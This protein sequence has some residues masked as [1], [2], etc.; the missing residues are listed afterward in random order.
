M[1]IAHGAKD[2]ERLSRVFV[3]AVT[4]L[5]FV[6]CLGACFVVVNSDR[7][8]ILMGGASFAASAVPIAFV[9]LATLHRTY[10]QVIS[11]LYYATG[12]TKFY[13]NFA[14]ATSIG[15]MALAWFL[16]APHRYFGLQLGA[17][18]LAIKTL[19]A[20]AL[21]ANIFAVFACRYLGLSYRPLLKHQILCA[22]AFL[23]L[24]GIV[25]VLLSPIA[26]SGGGFVELT[27]EVAMAGLLY[28]LG[29][30]GIVW[31]FPS[32]AGVERQWIQRHARRLLPISRNS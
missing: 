6:A 10:G 13:R 11:T 31:V 5:Y 29:A 1:S 24:A 8:S 28:I 18:G 30:A 9:V 17:Q 19:I 32:L 22:G 16:I 20:E 2:R 7:F 21:T 27:L 12:N 15:G 23:L 14:I 25:R 4:N 3:R 26:S